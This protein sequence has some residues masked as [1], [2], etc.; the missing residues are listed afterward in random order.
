MIYKIE[1]FTKFQADIVYIW[2][3][4][5]L[6]SSFKL[7]NKVNHASN[8]IYKGE[9]SCSVTYIGETKRNVEVRWGEHNSSNEKSEPSKHLVANPDHEFNWAI[10]DRA[11]R[12]GR[13][14]KILEAYHIFTSKPT[15][16]NKKDIKNLFLFRNG[17]T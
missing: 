12:N 13:K 9:C 14:R 4:S 5:K 3:T 2:K 15:L 7:K 17:V 1:K 10:I 16:N 11:S 8:V 6:R